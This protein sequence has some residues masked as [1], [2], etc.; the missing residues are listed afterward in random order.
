ML[1]VRP[2][3]EALIVFKEEPKRDPDV[4]YGLV[5]RQGFEMK[6]GE[7]YTLLAKVLG[8]KTAVQIDGNVVAEGSHPGIANRKAPY[9]FGVDG[10][11]V[12]IDN[13]RIWVSESE[14]G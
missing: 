6:P 14:D 10:G 3:P 5:A 4:S 12:L 11:H 7:L 13:V 1:R 9:R 2:T 8:E